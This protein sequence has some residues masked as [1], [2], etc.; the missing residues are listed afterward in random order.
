MGISISDKR[1]NPIML[2]EATI[3]NCLK[4]SLLTIT[5]VAKPAAVVRFVMNV[6]LPI[7]IITRCKAFIL[8][9]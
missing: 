7:F 2:K 4:I 5:K 8:L 3:P 9:P 6:A 1:Y